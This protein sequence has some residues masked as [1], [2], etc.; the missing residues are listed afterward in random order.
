ME[1]KRVELYRLAG[2]DNQSHVRFRFA[3]A[4]T[5]SWYFGVDAFGIYSIPSVAAPVATAPL[6][7]RRRCLPAIILP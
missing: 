7:Q 5:D 6:P 2:A 4:G 1:S 3:H